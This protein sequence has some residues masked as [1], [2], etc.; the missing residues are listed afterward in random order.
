MYLSAYV[1]SSLV[2]ETLPKLAEAELIRVFE[3]SVRSVSSI[4]ACS[5]ASGVEI[6]A[7]AAAANF[8]PFAVL[9]CSNS[10]AIRF[11]S[12]RF[13]TASPSRISH[14]RSPLTV[15]PVRAFWPDTRVR[16]A[17]R[18]AC[19]WLRTGPRILQTAAG[20]HS[21]PAA[22]SASAISDRAMRSIVSDL[23]LSSAT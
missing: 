22:A 19:Q 6:A 13:P 15:R 7:K 8:L 4:Q 1:S 23:R 20:C 14:R 18:V 12:A 2:S 21:R 10:A 16:L 9:S 11:G 5:F 3:Y 17:S